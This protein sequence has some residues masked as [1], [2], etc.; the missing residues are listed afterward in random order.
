MAQYDDLAIRRITV[1]SLVSIAVTVVSILAVQ[2]LYYGMRS[3]VDQQKRTAARFYEAE[4]VLGR[5]TREISQYSVHPQDG[6]I[7]IPIEQ[8][9]RNIV[10]EAAER[11]ENQPRGVSVP[12]PGSEAGQRATGAAGEVPRRTA[13]APG[14]RPSRAH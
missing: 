12:T 13:G 5:Q 14:W 2:V 7:V 3:Y 6:N 4:E 8:A 9:M 10:R 1:V 11:N